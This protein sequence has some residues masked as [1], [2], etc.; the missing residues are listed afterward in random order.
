MNLFQWTGM[1]MLFL[2]VM[3]CVLD[4]AGLQLRRDV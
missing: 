2:S 4:F 1:A 3:V